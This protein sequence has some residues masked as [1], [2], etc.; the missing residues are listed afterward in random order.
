MAG[1]QETA[2]TADEGSPESS[3]TCRKM[4]P[5]SVSVSESGEGKWE[6]TSSDEAP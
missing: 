6:I 2:S 4:G 5:M 1:D 3:N